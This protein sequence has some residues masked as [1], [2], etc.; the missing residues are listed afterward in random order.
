MK[1]F[2][3]KF[4]RTTPSRR[5]F[6]VGAGG[7]RVDLEGGSALARPGLPR[8]RPGALRSRLGAPPGR[9]FASKLRNMY[10]S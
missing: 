9:L 10:Y 1:F 7:G 8:A 2:V 5:G 4:F 6:G 3:P